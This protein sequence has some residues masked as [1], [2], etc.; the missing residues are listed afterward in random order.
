MLQIGAIIAL[1]LENQT[2][3]NRI[4][5]FQINKVALLHHQLHGLAAPFGL[6]FGEVKAG[7]QV[8]GVF[9][10]QIPLKPLKRLTSLQLFGWRCLPSFLFLFNGHPVSFPKV[11]V[12]LFGWTGSSGMLPLNHP[13]G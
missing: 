3:K 9:R 7:L 4:G 11:L 5:P 2:K 1:M 6:G 13:K 8:E 10:F 12:G